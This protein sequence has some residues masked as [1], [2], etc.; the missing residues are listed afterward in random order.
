MVE[1]TVPHIA[2]QNKIRSKKLISPLRTL[3]H[4]PEPYINPQFSS[5]SQANCPSKRGRTCRLENPIFRSHLR[6]DPRKS[7]A[8]IICSCCHPER[9]EGSRRTRPAPNHPYFSSP[10][11]SV[12]SAQEPARNV[13]LLPVLGSRASA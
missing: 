5:L 6:I 10:N 1:V 13:T 3:Q 7:L 2:T 8:A 12:F 9:S 4:N 11:S